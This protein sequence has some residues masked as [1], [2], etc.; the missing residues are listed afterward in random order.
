ML[1]AL[2]RSEQLLNILRTADRFR[3]PSCLCYTRRSTKEGSVPSPVA[4]LQ[5]DNVRVAGRLKRD[6]L[7]FLIAG[8]V[9]A[10]DQGTKSLIRATL[11]PG[12][13]V[14]PESWFRITHVTNTGAAFGI[15]PDQSLLLLVTTVV[16][17]A[18]IV[19]YYLNPPVHSIF[20]T[21]SL[22][23]QLG[24]A[25]GNLVDRLRQ[26]YVTDFLD[27]RVWPVFN[28]A[29]SAIVVGVAILAAFLVL[30]DRKRAT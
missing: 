11:A 27:F 20:L 25:M 26:G 22:G 6:A 19:L 5:R 15:L 29:D 8:L 2:A 9:F 21:L 10:L 7:F 3:I 17:V 4:H 16:G 28:L 30:S 18:A 12:E 1:R 23:L 24:G 13:S 14:P